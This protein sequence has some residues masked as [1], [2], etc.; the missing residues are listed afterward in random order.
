MSN[1]G[2]IPNMSINDFDKCDFCSQAKIT[3]NPHK[4]VNRESETLDLIHS[5]ICELDG[6]L[7]RNEHRY[8]I[9]FINDC[10]DFT[11]IYLMKNK[12][13]AFEMFKSFVTEIENQFSKKVKRLRSDRG[14]EYES[15]MFIE[16]Y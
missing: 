8:F 1:L 16:F 12:S 6:T 10:S 4:S 9:T 3:K 11:Y 13:A 2:L 14:T 5:D 7:T 15:S